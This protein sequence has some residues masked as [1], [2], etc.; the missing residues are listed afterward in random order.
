MWTACNRGDRESFK[1]VD[2]LFS[3]L[4]GVGFADTAT[5]C[6]VPGIL[7]ARL[8]GPSCAIDRYICE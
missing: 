7:Y 2:K 8:R 3:F 5:K 6:P 4:I 1:A